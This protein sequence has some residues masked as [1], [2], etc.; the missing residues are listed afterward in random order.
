MEQIENHQSDPDVEA[1]SSQGCQLWLQLEGRADSAGRRRGPGLRFLLAWPAAGPER[2]GVKA[3]RRVRWRGGAESLA[4]APQGVRQ[5]AL[6]ARLVQH[7]RQVL[8]VVSS[9]AT[10]CLFIDDPI[11]ILQRKPTKFLDLPFC[12]LQCEPFIKQAFV[13]MKF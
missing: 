1:C 10:S 8:Q 6:A 9:F 5:V 4:D 13:P 11:C 2:A 12:R 3:E 7:V